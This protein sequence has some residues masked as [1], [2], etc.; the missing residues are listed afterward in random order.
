MGVTY[1]FV[2]SCFWIAYRTVCY[3]SREQ[4]VVLYC[5]IIPTIFSRN[6]LRSQFGWQ[7][8][9]PSTYLITQLSSGMLT[10]RYHISLADHPH[11]DP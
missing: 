5:N 1:S 4:L 3:N 2:Y 8:E 10:V 7:A 6:H 11:M 9:Y